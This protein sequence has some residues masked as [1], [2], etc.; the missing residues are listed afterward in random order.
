MKIEVIA[1]ATL[2]KYLPE[3]AIGETRTVDV[4]TGTSIKEVLL[5]LGLPLEEVRVI[6]RNNLQAELGDLVNEG[7]RIAFIPPIAGG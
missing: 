6:M 3:L 5:S 1:F 2:R 7:D 4:E